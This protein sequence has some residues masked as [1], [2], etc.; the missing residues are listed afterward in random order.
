M[1]GV[2]Q[3]R[4][5]ESAQDSQGP[6]Q[7]Q[8]QGYSQQQQQ[9]GGMS[10][11]SSSHGPGGAG[12]GQFG[13]PQQ[14]NRPPSNYGASPRSYGRSPSNFGAG[15]NLGPGSNTHLD[16]RPRSGG[17]D[18]PND[19]S[20]RPTNSGP[21]PNVGGGSQSGSQQGSQHNSREGSRRPT[22]SQPAA[23]PANLFGPSLGYDPA[24]PTEKKSVITNRRVE[25]PAAA[26]LLDNPNVSL[27]YSIIT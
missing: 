13:A 1:G 21:P 16:V 4:V 8:G 23:P 5:H 22:I 25:L 11:P 9:G 20:R 6:P 2:G 19:V 17:F 14:H 15:N 12:P 7:G 18:G 27:P 26:Y 24:K 10:R 3:R